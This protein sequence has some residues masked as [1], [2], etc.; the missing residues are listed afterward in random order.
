MHLASVPTD[1]G[2][3]NCKHRQDNST[4]PHWL[5]IDT[6]FPEQRDTQ[7]NSPNKCKNNTQQSQTNLPTFQT[8]PGLPNSNPSL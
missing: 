4:N 2:E 7:E 6:D 3:H 8:N 1:R 5:T